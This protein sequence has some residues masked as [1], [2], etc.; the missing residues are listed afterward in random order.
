MDRL[1]A[2]AY[3]LQD[4]FPGIPHI[5]YVSS[6]IVC[7]GIEYAPLLPQ[8][9]I[10]RRWCTGEIEYLEDRLEFFWGPFDHPDDDVQGRLPRR[11]PVKAIGLQKHHSEDRAAL[12]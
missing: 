4:N 10:S 8:G 2:Q 5:P 12:V 11:P 9:L 7:Q 6:V 1:A 3:L